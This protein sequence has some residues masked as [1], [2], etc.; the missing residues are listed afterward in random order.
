[1]FGQGFPQLRERLAFSEFHP[2][3]E[4]SAEIW[5][6]P[7]LEFYKRWG[8]YLTRLRAFTDEAQAALAAE[9]EALLNESAALHAQLW[10][11]EPEEARALLEQPEAVG[12][13]IWLARRAWE[14]VNAHRRGL[15]KAMSGSSRG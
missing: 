4:G 7:S 9:D 3:L 10:G 2:D 12:F 11:C 5:V 15:G 14:M 1:M 6:N 13:A 8:A